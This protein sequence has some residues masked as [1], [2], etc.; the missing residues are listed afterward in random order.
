MSDKLIHL[1]IY[2]NTNYNK[3]YFPYIGE[4]YNSFVKYFGQR[5]T[6]VWFDPHP[7]ENP[8]FVA[9]YK[10]NIET[11]L[12]GVE[13]KM[14]ESHREGWTRAVLES[15][16]EYVF[17]LEHDFKLQRISHTMEQIIDVMR[18]DN[19]VYMKFQKHPNNM[20]RVH[21]KTWGYLEAW[22]GRTMIPTPI[23][24]KNVRHNLEYFTLCT[25]P[26]QPQIINRQ[27][28]KDIIIPYLEKRWATSLTQNNWKGRGGIERNMQH[29]TSRIPEL[30]GYLLAVYGGWEQGTCAYH[31]DARKD[32][33]KIKPPGEKWHPGFEFDYTEDRE[34]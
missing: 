13:I 19:I 7:N 14:T 21:N 23:P 12:P 5:K 28:Y 4:A 30:Q 6:T 1:N 16:C 9:E 33:D 18:E 2:T 8:D 25:C 34:D 15:D 26:N 10:K 24:K 11:L 20:F 32:E 29:L 3:D 27:F 31:L 22:S 17:H